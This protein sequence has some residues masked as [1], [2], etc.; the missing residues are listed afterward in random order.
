MHS[1]IK[2]NRKHYIND[3]LNKIIVENDI[4]VT[5]KLDVKKMSQKTYLAKSILDASFGRICEI[6]KWKCRRYGKKY[7]QVDT[8]YPSSKIC[9]RCGGKPSVTDDLSVR[10]WEGEK[11]R[12][13]HDRDMNANIN[14]MTE[15]LR[16]HYGV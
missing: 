12:T 14:I 10:E 15:G 2:N 16:L 5:E 11:C 3:T 13:S 6:L 8:Y 9:S 4:I 1:K 7:Y